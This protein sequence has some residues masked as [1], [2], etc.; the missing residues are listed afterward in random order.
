MKRSIQFLI[1]SVFAIS[2]S[3]AQNT[4]PATGNVGIGIAS[5]GYPIQV[6]GLLGI[7]NTAAGYSGAVEI[8]LGGNNQGYIK[9]NGYPAFFSF[10]PANAIQCNASLYATSGLS[11]N[12]IV[13]S[14]S[15]ATPNLTISGTSPV[16]G[17]LWTATNTSG[18]GAWASSGIV[19]TTFTPSTTLQ[20]NVAAISSQKA[21]ATKINGIVNCSMAFNVQVSTANVLCWV[22]AA[23]PYA[24]TEPAGTSIGVIS[25]APN[26]GSAG[27]QS[28][29][30]VILSTTLAR[31]YFF[32]G[33]GALL[34]GPLNISLQ[35]Y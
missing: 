2:F 26:A 11:S 19:S 29:Y 15:M 17:E 13:A 21:Q 33:P 18:A 34:T 25:Y 31:C 22:D 16:P 9:L 28:G 4:F 5:P 27:I 12:N 30:A 35:Y 32:S 24:P 14:N 3:F 6:N 1:L 20:N 8:G 23:I 7:T 10:G